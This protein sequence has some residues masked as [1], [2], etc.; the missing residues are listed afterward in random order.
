MAL[1]S[2]RQEWEAV[3]EQAVALNPAF[4]RPRPEPELQPERKQEPEPEP[5]QEPEPKP[6][7]RIKGQFQVGDKVQRRDGTEAWGI[8]HVTQ[9][10]PLKVNM[11]AADPSEDGFAW[12][13]VR[14]FE[15]SGQAAG[16][17]SQP[18]HPELQPERK[19]EPQPQPQPQPEP[20]P[21][22]RSALSALV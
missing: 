21:S 6:E 12:D 9:L 18:S 4:G 17:D 13:E 3:W 16:T 10:K 15:P 11:S 8:G 2:S 19:Q 20:E 14:P 5:Q 22:S 7:R 1:I